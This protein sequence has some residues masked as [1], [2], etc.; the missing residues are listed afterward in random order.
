MKRRPIYVELPIYADLERLWEATQNPSLHEQ[1]DLRFTKIHYLPKEEGK[2]QAFSY[3]TKLG[4]FKVEGW[5]QSVGRFHGGDGSRT[6]SLHFGTDQT[7]SPIR[8]GRGYWKYKPS[9]DSITFLT[10]YNYQ[11]NFGSFGSFIDRF[12]FRPV[13]GWGTALSFDVL[14][15]WLEKGESPNQQYKRFFGYWLISFLFVFIWI[16]HGAIPKLLMM[17]ET[18]L[19]MVRSIFPTDFAPSIVRLAGGIE[20]LFGLLF[21]AIRNKRR[22]FQLQMVVFMCLTLAALWGDVSVLSHPFNPLTF[23]LALILLSWLGMTTGEDVP[24]AKFCKRKR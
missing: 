14:K 3:Q 11:T 6:S 24:T 7:I 13:M 21:L 15:R 22:L 17:H 8:E 9:K 23:N 18:E 4:P 12:L 5:G 2:P 16:Y 1:W 10:E 20:I 19:E